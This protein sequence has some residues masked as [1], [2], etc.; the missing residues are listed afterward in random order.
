[1]GKKIYNTYNQL[2]FRIYK[3]LLLINLKKRQL[4]RKMGKNFNKHFTKKDTHVPITTGK[5]PQHH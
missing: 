4:I 5:G 3:E 2:V 1:M